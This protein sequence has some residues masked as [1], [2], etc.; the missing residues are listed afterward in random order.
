MCCKFLLRRVKSFNQRHM[1]TAVSSVRDISDLNLIEANN[2]HA[3]QINSSVKLQYN[4]L[5]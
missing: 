5:D 2:H 1:H 3:F 4:K